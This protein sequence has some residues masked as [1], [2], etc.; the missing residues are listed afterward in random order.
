V[1]GRWLRPIVEIVRGAAP[2][3][4]FQT[5]QIL[6]GFDSFCSARESSLTIRVRKRVFGAR[7]LAGTLGERVITR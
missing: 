1:A 6:L 2:K 5:T 7:E 3:K 4:V